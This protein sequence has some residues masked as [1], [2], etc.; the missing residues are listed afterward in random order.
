[1][2]YVSFFY[3]IL[4]I[5]FQ[6]NEGV[7]RQSD[8]PIH[9]QMQIGYIALNKAGEYGAYALR[10]GFQAAIKTA[11]ENRLLDVDALINH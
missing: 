10:P 2:D 11:G 5:Y 7:F 8:V 3:P 9:P 4:F 6:G 1:M